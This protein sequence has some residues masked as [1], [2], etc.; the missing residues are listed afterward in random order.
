MKLSEL[1]RRWGGSH[2]GQDVELVSFS[3]DSRRLQAGDCFIALQGPNFD[4]EAFLPEVQAAG[5]CAAVVRR[6]HPELA[7]PQWVVEDTLTAMQGMA[8][9]WRQQFTAR[10]IAITGSSGK[11]TCKQ[12]LT[13][14]LRSCA[15]TL[16]T[17]GN[18]NNEVGVPQTLFALRAEHRYAVIELGAN[19]PGEIAR[20]VSLVQPELVMIT[21]IGWAHFAGFGGRDG[22][23]AAKMEIYSGLKPGATVVVNLDDDYAAACLHRAA[24]L[25]LKSVG[26]SLQDARAELYAS[27]VKAQGDGSYSC[28]PVWR[29]QAL[30]P[31]RLNMPGLHNLGNACLVLALALLL[32]VPAEQACA[33]LAETEQVGGRLIMTRRQDLIVIDDT[34]N[35]N[36]ASCKAAIDVLAMQPGRKIVVLGD[37]KELG[38]AAYQ[39]HR[40]VGAWAKMK[41]IDALYTWGEHAEDYAAG[42]GE[43]AR[44]F[45]DKAHLIRELQG[46]LQGV[47]SLLVKGSRSARMEEVVKS[48]LDDAEEV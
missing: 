42:Y 1:V 30:P 37:M 24:D 22:I 33:A 7:L 41:K 23:A 26:V 34:Y 27:D 38:S 13:G 16:A 40:D 20:T 39:S 19:H 17:A 9:Q 29:G 21:N 6:Y 46:E 31:L 44:V 11:T 12:M 36:P 4:G 10:C 48:L 8:Q 35:A 43:T 28:V 5:A 32:D 47:V 45:V 15:P 2:H 3:T 25:Q 18:L 14:V